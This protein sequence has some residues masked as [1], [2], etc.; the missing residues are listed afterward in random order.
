MECLIKCFKV[1]Q[2]I[3]N[4]ILIKK[5]DIFISIY[6]HYYSC[7]INKHYILIPL[8]PNYSGTIYIDFIEGAST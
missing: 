1:F 4:W 6:T 7:I 2:S 8:T 3:K 5:V